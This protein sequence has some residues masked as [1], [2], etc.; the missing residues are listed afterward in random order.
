MEDECLLYDEEN[1]RTHIVN[2]VAGLVW[3]MCDGAHSIG[4]M[5]SRMRELY[6]IPRDVNVARDLDGIIAEFGDLG[7][8]APQLEIEAP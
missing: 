6:D 7:L 4:D 8:L 2:A 1:G 3:E 5:E